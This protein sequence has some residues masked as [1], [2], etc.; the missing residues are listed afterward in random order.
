MG[1]KSSR[2]TEG[3]DNDLIQ[4]WPLTPDGPLPAI[5]AD[6]AL[7]GE[8][9]FQDLVLRHRW[10]P[11][12]LR[13]GLKQT[14]KRLGIPF[15]R[16]NGADQLGRDH[17]LAYEF[18]NRPEGRAA[19]SKVE[20]RVDDNRGGRRRGYWTDPLGEDLP[21][22]LWSRYQTNPQ[23][24]EFVNWTADHGVARPELGVRNAFYLTGPLLRSIF[25]SNPPPLALDDLELSRAILLFAALLPVPEA[26]DLVRA[27]HELGAL[28]LQAVDQA[29]GAAVE[30]LNEKPA[31][32]QM[33]GK[34][35]QSEAPPSG[36]MLPPHLSPTAE[37]NFNLV[38]EPEP[39]A[40][41][42]SLLERLEKARSEAVQ[43]ATEVE[44][45]LGVCS[46]LIALDVAEYASALAAI[47]SARSAY[48]A[49]TACTAEAGD[50]VCQSISTALARA[51]VESR[52]ELSAVAEASPNDLA[53]MVRD[54]GALS[55]L[56]Q[57]TVNAEML[58]NWR[59]H[60]DRA[61][62]LSD[63]LVAFRALPSIADY[64]VAKSTRES[65]FVEAARLFLAHSETSENDITRWLAS[66]NAEEVAALGA[67][68]DVQNW[69]IIA[70]IL[71]R[72]GFDV[73]AGFAQ[74][75]EDRLAGID[76]CEARRNLLYFFDPA[77][78]AY[79]AHVPLQRMMI[80]ERLRDILD[81]GQLVVV[82]DPS[83]MLMEPE[84]VGV[85]V[86]DLFA[87]IVQHLDLIGSGAE[88][89]Q[90]A[91][92]PSDGSTGTE[93][94]KA[95]LYAYATTM[96]PSAGFYLKLREA[97]R[98]RHFAPLVVNGRL[99]PEAA[100]KLA[101][102]FNVSEAIELAEVD[103]RRANS[104]ARIE[105][106][107]LA[108][109]QRYVEHGKA[110]LDA[111]ARALP[112]GSAT[113]QK[114]FRS[115]IKAALGLLNR[116]V[117]TIGTREWLEREVWLMLTDRA[118]EHE[119]STLHGN[120][121][122]IL[123]RQW[124][125]DDTAWAL[126]SIDLPYFYTDETISVA[127]VG[128]TTLKLW[129]RGSKL[130]T[131]EILEQL[132]DRGAWRPSFAFLEDA[133]LPEEEKAA[134][135]VHT[136]DAATAA[137]GPLLDRLS[138]L[139]GEH[140]DPLPD[141][142]SI[143]SQ[144]LR[145]SIGAFDLDEAS[146]HLDFLEMEAAELEELR[147]RQAVDASLAGERQLLLRKLLLVGAEG[148][149]EGW[150]L[151]DLEARWDAEYSR[152]SQDRAHLTAVAKILSAGD[153]LP[154]LDEERERFGAATSEPD[155]WLPA[156][157]AIELTEYIEP[158]ADKLRT[159]MQLSAQL[160][161]PQRNA[162]VSVVRW[163]ARFIEEQASALRTLDASQSSDH[164]LEQVLDASAAIELA[165]DPAACAASLGVV[166]QAA[167]IPTPPSPAPSPSTINEAL[168]PL[169]QS[170]AW[171]ELESTARA[172]RIE[173][174]DEDARRL[175]DIAEFAETMSALSD[176]RPED[177]RATIVTAARV[178]GASGH[179]INRAIPTQQQIAIAFELLESAIALTGDV[180][181]IDRVKLPT[182]GSWGSLFSRRT[183]LAIF[184][185][186]GLSGRTLE[187]LCSGSLGREI[188]TRVWEAPKATSEP[189]LLRTA[190][191][192][193][194][195]ERGLSE[196]LLY[197]AGRYENSIK[198]RLEQLLNLR[199]VAS[200]RPDLVPVSEA[201]A[202]QIAKSVQS[203]PFR[204]F[205]SSLPT[206]V[207]AVDAELFVSVDQDIIL[208]IDRRGPAKLA[209]ALR[210]E[211][212]GLVPESIEV[213]L[214]PDDDVAFSDGTRRYKIADQPIYFPTE[215]TLDVS[216]GETWTDDAPRKDESFKIR[217]N[218]R[219]LA[220]ELISRD[221][222]CQ[223]TRAD[224][225][226]GTHRRIDDDTLLETFPG[227]ENTPALGDTFIGRHDELE[228]LNSALVTARRPSP[229]LLTGMRRIGKTSLLYAFHTKHRQPEMNKPITV[230]FSLAERRGPMM[231]PNQSV[232]ST[233]YAAIAQALGKRHF[234]ASDA[235]RDLGDRLKQRFGNERD[236]VRNAIMDLRDTES[237][238][239]SLAILSEKLLEWIGGAP[240]IIYLIDEAETLV[241]PYR[242]GEAKRLELEQ[243]MQGLREVSQTSPHVGL[244]LSGSNHIAD[245]ARS[246]KNAFFGSSLQIDLAGMTDLETA[247]R[248]ISPDK[249]AP[250]LSFSGEP[251]RYGIDMC[252]GMPQ[253]LWQL[254]AATSAN[255]R[256]GPVTKAD[257]RQ[258]VSSLV[259][260]GVGDL[261]FKA[262]DVLE[263][264][265]HMIGLQGQ[266]E[267][268]LLWLLL[269]RVANSSSLVVPQAQQSYIVDQSLLELDEFE[270]WKARLLALVDLEIL[271]M[272]GPSMYQFKVPIFAEGFRAARQHHSY[273]MR[274]QRA[275][276]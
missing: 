160:D 231:D 191:L 146:E 27:A 164:L 77:S 215:Y 100:A 198:A 221:E 224:L 159:W 44:V 20:V 42:L 245:F 64:I 230:Y 262:Y 13:R 53:Y 38:N 149:D 142:F 134:L 59:P 195:Y 181:Q 271:E 95:E 240:R 2:S 114:A 168:V 173:A 71:M 109:I 183:D 238:A 225:K 24:K 35:A 161:S 189:A 222:V 239:D 110:L 62:T 175:G 273:N 105:P 124:S 104:F 103:V 129:A 154:E 272:P 99:V 208:R 258:G 135:E 165:L 250:Y 211:P 200:Q 115:D 256:S 11:A 207:Q 153:S 194:L 88:L 157:R 176:R 182:D 166:E 170:A 72:V 204:S 29:E 162:L 151:S 132:I 106:R 257:I 41:A 261:P 14:A 263:P 141:N 148:P 244:L 226:T 69:P 276:I 112:A 107:H 32:A 123:G 94:V 81:F 86:A 19:L 220:G 91:R 143:T 1:V 65:S 155:Q 266:R 174:S 217:V 136:R 190:L 15:D 199:S 229:V 265:E 269:W 246:Y 54:A 243:L 43:T 264:I 40:A 205:V 235:N 97:V 206:A 66:L 111:Y 193:F 196:H 139:E 178:L 197:L 82:S 5:L 201:V 96:S 274:H 80:A 255:V 179:I 171:S 270:G 3:S 87:L 177:A 267:L 232:S 144:Q 58:I 85:P 125:V 8:A 34:I 172:L 218:A 253:F 241:L 113:R 150:S 9:F 92:D 252:A 116:S 49:C 126:H 33:T 137:A 37:F 203:V 147:N 4:C 122:N 242:G 268:D 260:G 236:A 130:T 158:A 90:L 60:I 121:Q 22:I 117:S 228:R 57:P 127:D 50:Y 186:S 16:S 31:N 23:L 74:H 36:A 138:A 51:N 140:G 233:F 202:S 46:K 84:I 248:L 180:R 210:I 47:D 21:R 145:D 216:F 26:W 56:P 227:V 209:V 192:T 93:A 48:L 131:H 67:H 185:A 83:L 18:A 55:N 237:L 156:K 249:L 10:S 219:V 79:D 76:D 119:F 118:R 108:R 78:V 45:G 167:E 7:I 187:Q 39:E 25:E 120:P 234:S 251:V 17:A 214:F 188:V 30:R 89:R 169:A 63:L 213:V 275:S 6:P 102:A 68:I 52:F 98:E 259:G 61:Q 254:G 133:N 101:R 75:C 73:D 12:A 184:S 223:L 28:H 247:R 70:A 212:R 152:R 128:A 163:F